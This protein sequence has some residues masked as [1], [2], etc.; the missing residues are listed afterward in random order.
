MG[1]FSE[2]SA[3]RVGMFLYSYMA[4]G[5]GTL[6]FAVH[7]VCMNLCDIYYS[8]AQGM[9]KASLVLSASHL[10]AANRF[11]AFFDSLYFVYYF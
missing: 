9:G 2:Q 11:F 1:A 10:A 4:A 7:T 5:L 8:F 3:E 6:S